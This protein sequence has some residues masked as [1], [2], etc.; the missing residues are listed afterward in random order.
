MHAEKF[1]LLQH[2]LRL[3]TACAF[4][5]PRLEDATV[6]ERE[7]SPGD[8]DARVV[9]AQAERAEDGV[10]AAAHT[11]KSVDVQRDLALVRGHV[12]AALRVLAL[13]DRGWL[14]GTA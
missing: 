13:A 10:R 4:V 11:S 7:F 9:Q 5:R 2:A 8:L 3:I 14:A 1:G 6:V 12:F